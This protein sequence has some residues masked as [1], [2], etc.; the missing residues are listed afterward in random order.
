MLGIIQEK[1]WKVLTIPAIKQGWKTP[2]PSQTNPN[3]IA[4]L[5]K[6]LTCLLQGEAAKA[7]CWSEWPSSRQGCAC[8]VWEF[9]SWLVGVSRSPMTEAQLLHQKQESG[10]EALWFVSYSR[11]VG[12]MIFFSSFSG[13]KIQS[14]YYFEWREIAGT[15]KV[16]PN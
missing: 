4:F 14:S 15:Y 9:Y 13:S 5:R 6:G 11:T 8:A 1:E 7:F 10:Q 12:V 3:P 2:K 16:S